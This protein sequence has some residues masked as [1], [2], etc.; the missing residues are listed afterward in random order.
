MSDGRPELDTCR[1]CKRHVLAS[2]TSCPFCGSYLVYKISSVQRPKLI[3]R[4]SRAAVF[5]AGLAAA[6]S[7]DKPKEAPA[8]GSA[9]SGSDDLEKLLDQQPREV[10]HPAPPIDAAES[11]ALSIDA[12]VIDAGIDIAA[13]KKLDEKK[14]A[15]KKKREHDRREAERRRREQEELERLRQDQLHNAMPYGAPPARRRIV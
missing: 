15:D 6:C 4:V 11:I 10:E 2:E 8:R 14:L 13:Q 5:S 3:G 12:A 9:G 1:G 7:G